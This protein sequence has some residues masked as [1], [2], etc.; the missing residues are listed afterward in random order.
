MIS[1]NS[2]RPR[3][4]LRGLVAGHFGRLNEFPKLGIF[5]QSFVFLHLQS[6]AEEKIFQS[7]AVED[8]VNDQTQLVAFEINPVIAD[9]KSVQGASSAFEFAE[10]VKFRMH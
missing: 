3:L 1:R 8:P 6:R 9:A 5:L 4:I 2:K 10:L 7:M